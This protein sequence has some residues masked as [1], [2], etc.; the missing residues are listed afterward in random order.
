MNWYLAKLVFQVR[1]SEETHTPQFEEQCRL[2]YADE[3]SW[4]Y[5]KASVLGRLDERGFLSHNQDTAAKKFI[6]VADLCLIGKWEDGAKLF[7]VIEKPNDANAYLEQIKLSGQNAI[8]LAVKNEI[9]SIQ[10]NIV[11]GLNVH[12][13][14]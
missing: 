12:S 2:I 14:E 5:E 9:N 11:N 13:T 8:D 6:E 1:S 4:A 3:V 10:L 7:S